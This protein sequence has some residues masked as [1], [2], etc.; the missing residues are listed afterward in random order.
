MNLWD[1]V[2]SQ[3]V[4]A[5]PEETVRQKLIQKMI[6]ELGFPKGLM[7]IEKKIS[8]SRRFDILCNALVQGEIVPLLLVECKAAPLNR[9]AEQQ[10][11]GYSDA[12][13]APFI[14]L[15]NEKEVRTLW[16][17]KGRIASIP[18]LPTYAELVEK[19]CTC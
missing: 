16:R 5:A 2:R 8:S 3:W 14:C 7:S 12:V 4:A 15:A 1:P 17:E 19:R 6:G 10:A 18:F 13:R 9:A 11:L